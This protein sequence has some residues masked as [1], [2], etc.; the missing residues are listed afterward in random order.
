MF[1]Y[2]RIT[3][4]VSFTNNTLKCVVR[5]AWLSSLAITRRWKVIPANESQRLEEYYRI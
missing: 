3:S 5:G 1:D 2:C 4:I